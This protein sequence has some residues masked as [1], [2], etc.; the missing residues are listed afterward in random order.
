MFSIFLFIFSPVHRQAIITYSWTQ[1]RGNSSFNFLHCSCPVLKSSAVPEFLLWEHYQLR[2]NLMEVSAK[3]CR[4][5]TYC[6]LKFDSLSL[7]AP[8]HL[9]LGFCRKLMRLI[10]FVKLGESP[11][12]LLTDALWGTD[13]SILKEIIP[14]LHSGVPPSRETAQWLWINQNRNS[15]CTDH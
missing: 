13:T 15:F 9:C 12:Q 6:S 14:I 5:H 3:H 10:G 8:L 4:D 11:P 2:A 7:S 1:M